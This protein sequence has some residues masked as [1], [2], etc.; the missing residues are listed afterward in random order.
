MSLATRFER[1][2]TA[3]KLFLILSLVML[4]IGL[5]LT[6]L[7]ANGIREAKQAQQGRVEDQARLTARAVESLIA[8]NT[9]ALRIAANG[10]LTNGSTDACARAQR[11]L[12]IAPAVAQHFQ[13]HSPEGI[14]ICSVGRRADSTRLPLVAPG[15]IT[16]MVDEASQAIV[17]RTGVIGGMA[18]DIIPVQEILAASNEAGTNIATLSLRDSDRRVLPVINRSDDVRLQHSEWPVGREQ[19]TVRVGMVPTTVAIP[20][21]LLL[22][23][24]VLMWI[25]AAFISWLLVTRLFIR[26][27]RQLERAVSSFQPGETE[28]DLPDRLGPSAEIQQLRDSFANALQRIDTSE[29]DMGV[30]LEGQRRLVREV[31]HRVKNN[32]Q[33][34]ASLLNI[35]GRSAASPEARE[36]YVAI[37]RRVGALSVVHRNHFAELEESRGIALRPLLSELA[38][39]LRGSAPDEARQFAIDLEVDAVNTT[40]D[41]AVAVAFLITEMVEHAMLTAADEPVEIALRRTS[42]LTARLTINSEVLNPDAA[43]EPDKKQF[44]RIVGGLAKQLRSPLERKLG[45]YS[46]E[47]PVFPQKS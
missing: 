17:I 16:V 18:T 37:G 29:R 24:P 2:P 8:R 45:R 3:A 19:L 20:E 40:Q 15:D 32:L 13:L 26:P 46:V 31:H 14:E 44:E 4:P 28:L 43:E 25:A 36:A 30:A 35:H 12:S 1:L 7:G 11:S 10:A 6:W 42:E 21:R 23:L 38:A 47:F 41:V 34:V 33:V 39:E 22:L 27:L 9:L 5:A